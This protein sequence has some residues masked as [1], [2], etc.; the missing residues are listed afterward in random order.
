MADFSWVCPACGRR[1]PRQV[2]TCRCGAEYDG[3]ADASQPPTVAAAP[4]AASP[5]GSSAL[6]T[7]VAVVVAIGAIAG[8]FHWLNR[9][10]PASP[11]P[12]NLSAARPAASPAPA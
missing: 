11:A 9:E 3:A 8:V 5:T 7:G 2:T 4:A 6:T 10:Q 12:A 1:I